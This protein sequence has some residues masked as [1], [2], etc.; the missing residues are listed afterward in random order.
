VTRVLLLAA[1][2]L[3]FAAAPAA[4]KTE[5]A[6]SGA[7]RAELSYTPQPDGPPKDIV[8]RVFDGDEQIVQKRIADSRYL[9][10]VLRDAVRARD[11]DGDGTAEA[12]FDLFTGGA[13]CC[14]L[15]YLYRG[16][17]EIERNWGNVGYRLR[18]VDDD[19]VT[20][21][22][23][24]DDRFNY[25]YA[26]YAGSLAPLQVLRLGEDELVD[27]TRDPVVT[28]LLRREARRFRRI[29]R[30]VAVRARRDRG[31]RELVRSSLAAY[32]ADLCSLD[33]CDTGYALIRR[34]QRRGDV[35]GF[36]RVVRSDMQTLGYD[37]VD[38]G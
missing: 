37:T 7:I 22:V 25:R 14:A 38:W 3:L 33:D 16:T 5:V 18:D 23:S 19:G 9:T 10:P 30:N 36:L 4:A 12:I 8:L 24:A 28:P 15:T 34:A 35:R 21:L 32:T 20:E 6:T 1:A 11:L 26:S 29:Y 31:L 13:H 2:A 27:A 17:T